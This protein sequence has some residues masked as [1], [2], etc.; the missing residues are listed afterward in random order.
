MISVFRSSINL[1]AI[2]AARKAVLLAAVLLA[3][4][5]LV[6]GGSQWPNG[7]LVH[8]I[9][10]W[11]GIVL[12]VFAILGRTWCSFYIG[13]RKANM[14]VIEGP[15]SVTRN[16]LYLFSIIGTVGIGAQFGSVVLA[17]V[18]GFIAWIVFLLVVLKEE[19]AL[20]ATFRLQYRHY[21]ARVPRFLPK[22]SHWQ[23]VEVLEV[24]TR[25]VRTTFY[26][27][28]VFLVSIPIAEGF[29]YIHDIGVLPVLIQLP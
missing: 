8:E 3:L 5:L 12:I 10:E 21:V 26:D 7:G 18:A 19:Q 15:Y 28:C 6:V 24:R 23:D 2:Q 9:I 11:L 4:V 20:D 13:G 29:E 25:S 22:L 14:L 17:L 1:V 16:P 27:A